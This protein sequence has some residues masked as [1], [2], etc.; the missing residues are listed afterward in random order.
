GYASAVLCAYSGALALSCRLYFGIVSKGVMAAIL[1]G[2]L[3]FAISSVVSVLF[4]WIHLPRVLQGRSP[5]RTQPAL[6]VA[7]RAAVRLA[8]PLTA[9]ATL[10]VR[11]RAPRP[12][13]GADLERSAAALALYLRPRHQLLNH[14]TTAADVLEKRPADLTR[15]REPLAR[16][17]ETLA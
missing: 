12:R 3:H 6:A 2:Y 5:V 4:G 10:H 1:F 11:R 17:N 14:T 8:V 13:R 7:L 16:Q 15:A 9:P